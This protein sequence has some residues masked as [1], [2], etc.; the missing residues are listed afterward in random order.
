MKN[1]S[2]L[3][4][5]IFLLAYNCLAQGYG[6]PLTMQGINRATLSS[7]SSLAAGGITTGVLNDVS[8]MFSNP[9]LIQTLEGAQVSLS[10]A[11]R[12][13]DAQQNQEW[14][15]LRYLPNFSLLMGG[16]TQYIPE[17]TDTIPL[18]RPRDARDSIQRPYDNIQPNWSR[19]ERQGAP[20]QGSVAVPFSIGEYKFAVGVGVVEY[21]NLDYYFQNNNVLSPSIGT[22]RPYGFPAPDNDTTA[23]WLQYYQSRNGSLYGYGGAFSVAL[24]EKLS[25][26]FSGLLLKG[27][28]DDKENT[29]GR[30]KLT[31]FNSSGTYFFRNDS[32]NYH[33]NKAGTSDFD[34]TEFTL[35][36]LYR[37]KYVILGLSVK[38]PTTISRT[39]KANVLVDSM[40]AVFQ[41][42]TAEGKD[43][44][45]LPWRGSFGLSIFVRENFLIGLE[46]ELRPYADAVYKDADG[47]ETRPWRSV[48]VFHAGATYLPLT[49]L[50]VRAGYRAQSEVFEPEGNPLIGD[51][52]K[53]SVYS[54]GFGLGYA[55][56][57]LN[58]AYEYSLMKYQDRWA[59][60]V[61]LNNT[62]Y[63]NIV[64]SAIYKIPW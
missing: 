15:P 35:S 52:V 29:V 19:T 6:S 25:L 21:A 7:A 28:A 14:F 56:I 63:Q 5:C 61:N 1:L 38:P 60:N 54:L 44:M 9:S 50:A 48:S 2:L 51:P 53:Y 10:G 34:G 3:S 33:V 32:I 11:Q 41:Q 4:S 31:F 58:L 46:Y 37:G 57:Q 43:E 36:G 22:Q 45:T 13:T 42:A 16:L 47:K 26:G 12:Y 23:Y 62:T 24:S 39:Y 49:W 20:L 55:N 30:G 59:T 27:T 64:A 18:S 8:L 17:P 40:G